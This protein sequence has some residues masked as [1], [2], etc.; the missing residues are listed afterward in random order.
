MLIRCNGYNSGVKEYLEGGMKSGRDLS[1]DE[2]DERIILD[3]D[4]ELT[5]RIYKNIPD[6]GQDRY[7]TFTLSFKEDE[8]SEQILSDV[9]QEFK[10]F[11]MTAHESDE[12][13]FYAEAHLPKI[14]EM[15]DK[16]TGE[17][18]DRKPHIHVVIPRVN[19][20]SGNEMNP[21]GDYKRNEKY[22][23][24]FQEYINQKYELAS[25]RDN[26]RATPTSYA[27][28]LSR[29]K[30]DDFRAKNK[31]F[32]EKI[33]ERVFSEDIRSRKDFYSLVSQYGETKIRN[34]GKESEYIAVKIEGDKKFT[35]LK[36]SIFSDEF[37]V[38]R[39][40][41]KP[42]LE[43]NIINSRFEEWGARAAEIKYIDKIASPRYRDKY[44]ASDAST[45][46]ELLTDFIDKFYKQHRGK[47]EL[48]DQRASNNQR[49]TIKT[50]TR[51]YSASSH[52]LQDLSANNVASSRLWQRNKMLLPRDARLHLDDQQAYG[53][54]GLRRPVRGPG[55]RGREPGGNL[56]GQ[57]EQQQRGG[58]QRFR[59]V[60]EHAEHRKQSRRPRLQLKPP[61]IPR[62]KNR[63]PT[64]DDVDKRGS[65]LFPEK[66]T[67]V[68]NQTKPVQTNSL[69]RGGAAR[70]QSQ[71]KKP[72]R[73]RKVQLSNPV[74]PRLKNRIPTLDDVKK[75]GSYLFP[76]GSITAANKPPI[77]INP[78]TLAPDASVSSVPGWLVR[79]VK[80]TSSTQWSAYQLLR[81]VDR[82]FY[83]IRKEV[84]TDKR[85]SYDE[86]TQLLS[87]M[88]FERL[89][90]KDAILTNKEVIT[91][92]SKDIRDLI[93]KHRPE[94]SAFTISGPELEK[95]K[96]KPAP[97][98]FARVM[99]ALRNPVNHSKAADESRKAVEK[100]LDASNLYTKRNR[101]GHVHYL[102]K[103]SD[104]T[105]FV[106]TGKHISMR[107]NGVSKDSVAIALELAQGR[108]GST[109]NIKG[110]KK[111]K[112]MVVDVVAEKGLDIHFTDKAMNAALELR[113][114]E[115]A[116]AKEQRESPDKETAFTIEGADKSFNTESNVAAEPEAAQK[117]PVK[118]EAPKKE[119]IK[120]DAAAAVAIAYSGRATEEEI[121]HLLEN[122][123][124]RQ[125]IM[126][127]EQKER[128]ANALPEVANDV[129][130]EI[131]QEIS[132]LM[133]GYS[134]IPAPSLTQESRSFEGASQNNKFE[135]KIVKHGAAP[136][137]E[138][139]GN[140]A[141]YFVT[142]KDKSGQEH[143]HWGVGLQ[144]ALN[145]FKRGHEISLE[146]KQ[147]EPVQVRSRDEN[148]KI[149]V[150]DAV[151]NVWEATRLDGPQPKPKVAKQPA[152][153]STSRSSRT[154]KADK[155]GVAANDNKQPSGKEVLRGFRTANMDSDGPDMA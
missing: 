114:M 13:N 129:K 148:G 108:F 65:H 29:Y 97:S 39:R 55:G 125:L 3:G 73:R 5:E 75:R 133:R 58:P 99:D 106:D 72:S 62:L 28:M 44:Y 84:L 95:D 27:D 74:I 16:K 17:K 77:F 23:E 137:L 87:I 22:F 10:S 107:K 41:S 112:E 89:K 127:T 139:E 121:Q 46:N 52:S 51:S 80:E 141:S 8:I 113:R 66:V 64:L 140:S 101:K 143:T 21:V 144:D 85:F 134:P 146:L 31:N 1:R 70:K 130:K 60:A 12:Y 109:L 47:Y 26:M 86:K 37:I 132:A 68:E 153:K 103:T 81:N 83:E 4:L 63:I 88:Q 59:S 35:N 94:S 79:R 38:D 105:L 45:K 119:P 92:G 19:L 122:P 115:L 14:R 32:K 56:D 20:L 90:R 147:T 2:L 18:V 67:T 57:P 145:G 9:V 6:K 53:D 69:Q 128:E 118:E 42:P 111:F 116:K 138:Q 154:T 93:N 7:L 142:L 11:L 152:D 33:L 71:L 151:R 102:D 120:M 78:S 150:R 98:R 124:L 15:L 76:E 82:E 36:E 61:V 135:G 49:S 117:T 43:R 24:A 126:S 40:L 104:K 54:S 123:N 30:G 136:Y 96:G 131:D 34:A 100:N 110:S 149:T 50:E 91:M 25:P 48:R 155:T